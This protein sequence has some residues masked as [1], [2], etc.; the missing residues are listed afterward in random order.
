MLVFSGKVILTDVT[1]ALTYV[2]S[3]KN[4]HIGTVNTGKPFLKYHIYTDVSQQYDQSSIVDYDYPA[5]DRK[6]L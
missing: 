5:P 2:N 3:T 6:L 1:F 4:D